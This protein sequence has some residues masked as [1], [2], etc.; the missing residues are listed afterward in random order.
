MHQMTYKERIPGTQRDC[1]P[2]VAIVQFG[3]HI[4]LSSQV[5]CET[6]IQIVVWFLLGNSPASECYTYLPTTMEQTV[7]RNVGIQNSDAGQL[8]RRKHTTFKTRR[9][10][11]IK[12]IT[13]LLT[14]LRTYSMDQSPCWE[15]NRFAASQEIPR[16]LWNPKV[17][18]RI[19]KCPP[20]VPILSQI[21]SIH[22]PRTHFLK[23]H[24]NIILPSKL[25]F[26]RVYDT[27]WQRHR[28]T[29]PGAVNTVKCS[30]WWAKTSPEKCRADKE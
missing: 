25:T 18:Y 28:W 17:H 24:L 19:H 5:A 27:S 29:L 30:W 6:N 13:Y 16:I 3:S 12:N 23:I 4:K 26:Q 14:H 20:A 7:F 1:K 11:E 9:R 2:G 10:L 8:P 21:D 15:A 22:T